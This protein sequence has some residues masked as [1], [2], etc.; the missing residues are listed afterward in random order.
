MTTDVENFVRV[1][2][3][4]SEKK[5]GEIMLVQLDDL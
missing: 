4:E 5:P 3:K 2:K 1:F